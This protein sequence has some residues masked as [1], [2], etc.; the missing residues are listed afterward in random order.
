MQSDDAFLETQGIILQLLSKFLGSEKFQH[1]DT[2]TIPSK[3]VNLISFIQLNLNKNLTVT[4]LAEKAN[5]H[6]DYFSRLFLQ[7]TGERPLSY[8][9]SKRIERA[10]YL[11]TTSDMSLAQIA[12]ETGFDNLPHFSKVFKKKT[13][14]TPG[15]YRQQN[16]SVNM[17]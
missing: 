4:K 3:V 13:S 12:E 6:P 11:I 16:Y 10:Q 5:L 14:L 2:S 1:K 17:F 7:L 8:I 15:Q 9:H